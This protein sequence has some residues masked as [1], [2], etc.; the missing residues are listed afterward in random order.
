VALE[1]GEA[2]LTLVEQAHYLAT[3]MLSTGPDVAGN[4]CF[5]AT[6]RPAGRARRTR[7]EAVGLD[8]SPICRPPICPPGNA[9]GCRSPSSCAAPAAWLLDEPTAALDSAGRGAFQVMAPTSRQAAERRRYPLPLG[10]PAQALH[11]GPAFE[12][13]RER[14]C[15]LL[16]PGYPRRAAGRRPARFR[17]HFLTVVVL[18]PFA[19]APTGYSGGLGLDPVAGAMWRAC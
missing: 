5:S 13:R 17:M 6:S 9:G 14:A 15:A 19:T 18:M 2:D 1:G 11:I 7:A 12:A 16:R 4:R 10:I 3:A 8:R